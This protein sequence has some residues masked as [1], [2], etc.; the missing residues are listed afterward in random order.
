MLWCAP[1]SCVLRPRCIPPRPPPLPMPAPHLYPH[2][3]LSNFDFR[4]PFPADDRLGVRLRRTVGSTV[5]AYEVMSLDALAHVSHCVEGVVIHTH[6][7][8]CQIFEH[9]DHLFPQRVLLQ[10]HQPRLLPRASHDFH[11]DTKYTSSPSF[12]KQ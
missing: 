2:C 3:R 7:T 6:N 1:F 4:S 11:C 8:A 5:R 9:A 10:T 12:S